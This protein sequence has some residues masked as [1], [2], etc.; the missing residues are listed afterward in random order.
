M[1]REDTGAGTIAPLRNVASLSALIDRLRNRQPHL[2]GMGAFYGP[3]GYGKSFAAIYATNRWRAVTVQVK[4]VW[5]PK[6][7]LEAV[8]TEMGVT[9]GPTVVRMLDQVSG[10]L[11][12]SDRP[13][14]VD[15]ADFLVKRKMIEIVR[16]IH[17]GSAAP[18]ILI[19][20]E[21]LP[22]KLQ[23][24][25]RIH[26]RMLSF[27]PAERADL[28]DVGHLARIYA[29]G[30]KVAPELQ[31]RILRASSG[32][33]RRICVNLDRVREFAAVKGLREVGLAEWG[34]QALFTGAAP[35]VR[36]F[37]EPSPRRG[38]A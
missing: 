8:L 32:A 3:S 1:T 13:L 36:R 22:Q 10:Q 2:P 24:W 30:V 27:V 31:A 9:P 20:E 28:S 17:E 14:I 15:E 38:A 4:S 35:E 16:D 18:V 21:M 23:A 34:D 25:E 29:A 33:T 37:E 6:T 7:L 19:G 11:A 12:I 5:T 26:N